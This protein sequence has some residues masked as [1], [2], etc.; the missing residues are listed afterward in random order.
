MTKVRK[1]PAW[2][3]TTIL[4]LDATI[5][6]QCNENAG[7]MATDKAHGT[8]QILHRQGLYAYKPHL[9]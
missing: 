5:T 9:T 3:M 4:M 7:E 6:L 1:R 8:N 2:E